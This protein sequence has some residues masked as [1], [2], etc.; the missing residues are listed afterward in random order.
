VYVQHLVPSLS[1]SGRMVPDAAHTQVNLLK[2]SLIRLETCR[3]L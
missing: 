2:M 1:M 3:G